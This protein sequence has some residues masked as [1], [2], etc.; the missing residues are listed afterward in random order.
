MN[1]EQKNGTTEDILSNI[2]TD[3]DDD[4]KVD[5]TLASFYEKKPNGS[6]DNSSNLDKTAI[7]DA[8]GINDEPFVPE[9]DI[10][11]DIDKKRDNTRKQRERELIKKKKQELMKRR[12]AKRTFAHVFGSVLL[13]IF[14]ISISAFLGYYTIR[15]ALDFTGIVKN[16]FEI[17]IEIP[18]YATTKEIAKILHNKGIIDLQ[19]FFVFYSGLS[20]S[21]GKYL[22]GMFT[23]DSSM[24]YSH[25]IDRLQTID[26]KQ[27][28]VQVRIRE[29]MTAK[30]I[31]ELLEENLVCRASDFEYFYK[32]KQNNY[33]FEKRVLAS[34]MK[35]YQLEGYLFPD[36]YEFYVINELS[37][38]PDMDTN[39]EAKTVAN[40]IY[41]NFN[42]KITKEI[43]KKTNEMGFTLD[44][45]ITL[46]SMVQAEA[47][48]QEDMRLVASV[49]LNRLNNSSD[50]PY[51]QSD[52]TTKY[53]NETIKPFITSKN[54]GIYTPIKDAYDTY[55]SA[56]LPPGPICN[57]GM[58]AIEA[59]LN[60]P[61]TDYLY[62]CANI[63]TQEIYYAKTIT[64]H[65]KN[66]QLANI[67][68]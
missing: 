36:T 35:F 63:E 46:A 12:E 23:F 38:N 56:G 42:S 15:A 55:K 5:A 40:K 26:R 14:I 37:E 29:G 39:T 32:N 18:E 49:F 65:E 68:E 53:G 61:K 20:G 34:S 1:E 58:T 8:A 31:G 52:V 28:T 62:F 67:T 47:G 17:E 59:V 27:E 54:S 2:I 7:I 41:S 50:Y 64:E 9:I 21:D 25:I 10:F 51:L 4:M 45:L 44:E 6:I 13:V 57:P 60:A 33:N 22:S 43:Y 66:L 16:E 3:E 24:S 48:T 19:E 30:E 11:S